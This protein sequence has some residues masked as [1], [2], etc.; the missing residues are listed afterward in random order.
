MASPAPAPDPL[1]GLPAE[2]AREIRRIAALR[3]DMRINIVWSRT[4]ELTS[5]KRRD[6]RLITV[7]RW[8]NW[9][10]KVDRMLRVSSDGTI[11]RE[12]QP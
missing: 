8:E 12:P 4:W 3:D 10:P 5:E 6:G 11:T 7:R 9:A 1:A 2:V